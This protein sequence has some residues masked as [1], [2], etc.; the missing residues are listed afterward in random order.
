MSTRL[1]EKIVALCG[2]ERAELDLVP[3]YT[4]SDPRFLDEANTERRFAFFDKH[5]K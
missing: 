4:H 3:G 5:L 2:Q 1:Y